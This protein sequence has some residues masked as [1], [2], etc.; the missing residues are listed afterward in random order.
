MMA[1]EI[2]ELTKQFGE[3]KVLQGVNLDIPQH[4]IFGFVG[5]NGAGKTTTM[6]ENHHYEDDFRSFKS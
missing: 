1:L 6:R 2:K 5:E 3:K 4:S